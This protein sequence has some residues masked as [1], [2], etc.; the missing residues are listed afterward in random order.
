[1][2]E[3]IDRKSGMPITLS[4]LY[5]EVGRRIGLT[6]DGVGFPG[7]FLV[8]A[9]AEGDEIVID[10]FNAG[11]IKSD[12]DLQAMLEQ[13]YGGKVRLPI[14]TFSRRCRRSK[15]SSACSAI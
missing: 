9:E 8:K 4:I 7:H 10:P 11:D 13:I 2:N 1:M 15:F 6:V 14:E 3:V 12:E 5:M